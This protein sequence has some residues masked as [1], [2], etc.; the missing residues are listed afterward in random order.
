MAVDLTLRSCRACFCI[1]DRWRHVLCHEKCRTSRARSTVGVDYWVA[2]S[3]GSRSRRGK[4]ILYSRTDDTCHGN[5]ELQVRRCYWHICL[6]PVRTS[7]LW[8]PSSMLIYLKHTTAN[9]S[10]NDSFPCLFRCDMFTH[11]QKAAR[12]RVVVWAD[13]L[14]RVHSNL[15]R[16]PCSYT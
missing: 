3:P 5:Y 13:Q 10:P 9:C 14:T 8:A 4:C 2:E 6:H 15:H 1:P 11:Y 16:T 7:P 12:N